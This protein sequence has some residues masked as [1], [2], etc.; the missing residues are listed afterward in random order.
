MLV[1]Q[2]AFRQKYIYTGY[3]QDSSSGEYLISANL[4]DTLDKIGTSTNQSGFFS[5]QSEVPRVT[6]QVTYVGYHPRTV[7]MMHSDTSSY[8][9]RLSPIVDLNA[10]EVVTSEPN[11]FQNRM[12]TNIISTKQLQVTPAVLGER[13]VLK[14][15]QFL[16]GVQGGEEG[17]SGLL[18]RGGG[19]D[20]NL[21]LLD[22]VPLYNTSHLFGFF[23]SINTDAIKHLV[24]MKGGFPARYAGRLSSVVDITTKDGNDQKWTG[25]L[26]VGM[27][28]ST[29]NL[30]GPI[31][32]GRTTMALSARRTLVDFFGK[33]FLNK[34]IHQN[35]NQSYFFS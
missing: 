35:G 29:V 34:A 14:T 27:I 30:E 25:D 22:G 18:V 17:Q 10:I 5:F 15:L 3:V 20:Q 16:P 2:L 9:I 1:L 33:S 19:P 12:G 23:S 28:A 8:N 32:K 24:V 11:N 13:D 4:Y 21:V 6:V 26:R 7:R 31:K